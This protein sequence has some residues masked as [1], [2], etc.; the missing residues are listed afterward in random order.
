M[1]Q[2]LEAILVSKYKKLSS[3]SSYLIYLM[4]PEVI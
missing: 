2:V 4:M 3:R 1:V